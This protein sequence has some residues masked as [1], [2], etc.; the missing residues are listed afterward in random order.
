MLGFGSCALVHQVLMTRGALPN[1]IIYTTLRKS[2][3]IYT[4]MG[5]RKT[6][7]AVGLTS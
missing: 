6:S 4:L 5:A 2:G 3:F 1:A 7:A